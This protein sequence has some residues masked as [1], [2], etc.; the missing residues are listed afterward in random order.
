MIVHLLR[1][2][3]DPLF[4]SGIYFFSSFFQRKERTVLHNVPVL[5]D[6]WVEVI[7]VCD[8]ILFDYVIVFFWLS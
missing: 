1:S 5:K 6:I 3:S 8:E 7:F 4:D 2:V